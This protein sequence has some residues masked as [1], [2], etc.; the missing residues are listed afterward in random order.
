MFNFFIKKRQTFVRISSKKKIKP[1][2]LY[3]DKAFFFPKF[4]FRIV[5]IVLNKN[6]SII[7]DWNF[8]N[9][10]SEITFSKILSSSF[11]GYD[12]FYNKKFFFY[13]NKFRRKENIYL[14]K[15]DIILFGPWPNIYFHQL[16]DFILRINFIKSKNYRKIYVPIYLKNILF[17]EPYKSIF[18]NLNF[19][20]YGYDKNIIFHNLRYISGLNH[21]SENIY[22]K[23]NIFN[24]CNSIKK[25]F[26]LESNKYNYS[27][28]SR[29]KS[30]R[31][32]VN[33]EIIF[34]K[35]KM[36]NFKR[37]YFEELDYLEQIKICYNSKIV[38]GLH[39][40]GLANLI[41]MKKN[42]NL[43]EITNNLIKNPVYKL[44]TKCAG[45]NYYS[46]SG[47]GIKSD[48][49]TTFNIRTLVKKIDI[50]LNK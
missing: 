19:N 14:D 3:L 44:L 27:F 22:L 5:G 36:Y 4:F 12:F 25:K 20:F 21:Y 2:V 29:N 23:K 28:I 8:N 38:I 35:L 15:K 48:L 7:K 47:L 16:I 49:S 46:I 50:I 30:S 24:L 11:F 18:S 17:S 37:Y 31:Y 42:N 40:S 10:L 41:F 1:K 26:S 34:E 33:E 32:L 6:R 39:G 13:I 45:V 9:F 43:I